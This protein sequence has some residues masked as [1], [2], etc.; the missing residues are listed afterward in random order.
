[1]NID[2]DLPNFN[3]DGQLLPD[4]EAFP[5]MA[6]GAASRAGRVNSL[7]EAGREHKSSSSA[8]APLQRKKRVPRQ[9]PVDHHQELRNADLAK[10]KETYVTNMKEAVASQ[11][12]RKAA[13]HAKK[14]AAYW[15]VGLGIGGIGAGIGAQK[16]K[17]P[18]DIF[19]GP[20]FLETLRGVPTNSGRK[21][22]RRDDDWSETDSESRNVR[23]RDDDG[24]QFVR[25]DDNVLQDDDT[26]MAPASEVSPF[27]L[28]SL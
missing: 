27:I 4:A 9:L 26:A 25:G 22:P 28:V 24:D 19:S 21:R 6:S 5:D 11:A 2:L 3:N 12:Q 1:M 17:S 8:S 10:W 15:V 13:A 20:A 7:L 18:L 14:N 23:A 16:I